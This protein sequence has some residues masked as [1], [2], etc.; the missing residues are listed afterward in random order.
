M[1]N[2]VQKTNAAHGSKFSF[3]SIETYT[4]TSIHFYTGGGISEK[5]NRRKP[6]FNFQFSSLHFDTPS[7]FWREGSELKSEQQHHKFCATVSAAFCNEQRDQLTKDKNNEKTQN[8][9]L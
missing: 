3:S 7:I 1:P 4:G 5:R 6:P 2:E 9:T 8:D